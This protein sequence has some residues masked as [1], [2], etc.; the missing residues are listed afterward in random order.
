MSHQLD[1]DG[2]RGALYRADTHALM[3]VLDAGSW[4][5][6]ALQLLG[7]AVL[8]IAYQGVEDVDPPARRCVADLRDRGWEGDAELAD[9]IESALGWGPTPL[10][11]AIDVDLEELAGLLE[12]DPT[13]GGGRIDLQTGAVWA[14]AAIDYAEEVGEA[15]PEDDDDERWLEV[16]CEGSRSGYRD[17]ELFVASLQDADVA[18]RLERSIQGRGAFRRFKDALADSPDLLG[19]WY[20]FSD[21]RHRGRARAWLAGEGYAPTPPKPHHVS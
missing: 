8:A 6:N 17:M 5:E 15:D 18:D 4:P 13:M 21:D 19:R 2:L 14:Q 20:G 9:Q 16:F 1:R 3:H 7:D 11:R 12:G 10:L